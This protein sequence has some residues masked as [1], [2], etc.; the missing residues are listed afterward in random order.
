[1][2]RRR[3]GENIVL[4]VT[5]LIVEAMDVANKI[6]TSYSHRC[7]QCVSLTLSTGVGPR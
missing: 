7:L 4:H 3:K 5:R 6:G 1:M 2:E